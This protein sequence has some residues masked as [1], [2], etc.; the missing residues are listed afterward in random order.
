[1][2]SSTSSLDTWDTKKLIANF[3]EAKTEICLIAKRE[4]KARLA[5]LY[6]PSDSLLLEIGIGIKLF[7]N[8]KQAEKIPESIY[9]VMDWYEEVTGCFFPDWKYEK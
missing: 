6:K 8:G 4:I 2:Q 3:K 7:V 5:N 9:Q 1:M